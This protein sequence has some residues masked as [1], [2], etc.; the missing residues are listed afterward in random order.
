MP[1]CKKCRTPL[2]EDAV[3]CHRCGVKQIR[4]R[5]GKKRGNGQGSVYKL[6]NGKYKAVAPP[7]YYLD[8][9]GVRRKHA[10]SKVCTK[11][12]DAVDALYELK[13]MA[14]ELRKKKTAFTFKE[15]YDR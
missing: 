5:T 14:P 11:M 8:E 4:E 15:L 1:N 2:P 9:N 10:P 6:P 12:A 3:F 7:T 13:R